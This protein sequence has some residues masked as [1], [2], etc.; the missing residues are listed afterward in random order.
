MLQKHGESFL[1]FLKN[2]NSIVVN[3]RI[4]PEYNDYTSVTVKGK[5][6]V[7]YITVPIDSIEYCKKFEVLQTTDL[8]DK[9]NLSSAISSQ[10]KAPDHAL[11]TVCPCSTI[12]LSPDP[13]GDP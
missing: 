10:C 6:V 7:D 2:A 3:G 1:E 13:V 11:L 5:S 12:R 9:L 8:I 4:T